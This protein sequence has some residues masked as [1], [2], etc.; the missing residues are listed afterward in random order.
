MSLKNHIEKSH[1]EL[2]LKLLKVD[3][4][5]EMDNRNVRK[6]MFFIVRKLFT[7]LIKYAL[8]TYSTYLS[9]CYYASVGNQGVITSL[10]SEKVP[11][12]FVPMGGGNLSQIIF[13]KCFL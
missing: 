5:G 13:V 4:D 12:C 10:Y 7:Q 11:L 9:D 1:E 2:L 8:N 6:I 3:G